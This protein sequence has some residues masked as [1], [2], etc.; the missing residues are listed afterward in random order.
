[1]AQQTG[2]D[3]TSEQAATHWFMAALLGMAAAAIP[4]Y[5]D[6][7]WIFDVDSPEFNPIVAV[8]LL[9]AAVALYYAA[10]GTLG[11][12]RRRRFGSSVLEI[13]GPGVARLG[14][15]LRGRVRTGTALRP[16]GD[17]RLALQ[18][19]DTHAFRSS[20]SEPISRDREFVVWEQVLTVAPEGL[21]ATQGIP[22]T[23]ELPESVG[24]D[25][26]TQP[27]PRPKANPHFRF[28]A[29]VNIPFMR[30]RVMTNE[31]PK[32]RRWQIDVSAPMDGA[33]YRAQFAVTVQ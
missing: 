7:R 6:M 24:K 32:A 25:V 28:K 13:E 5:F 11:T 15:P 14:R 17:Y 12:M 33:D 8:P 10:L 26:A 21:D 1:M 22:F 4:L 30:R 9:L 3:S 20:S 2:E 18:C 19:L 31:A 27:T 23:F 16:T 29:S